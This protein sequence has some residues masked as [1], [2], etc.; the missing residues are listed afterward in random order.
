MTTPKSP[1][2]NQNQAEIVELAGCESW[3]QVQEWFGGMTES[4]V[5][6]EADHCWNQEDNTEFARRV[7]EE[8]N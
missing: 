5:L 4:E 7:Y 8:L 6:A 3:E 2:Y 1:R